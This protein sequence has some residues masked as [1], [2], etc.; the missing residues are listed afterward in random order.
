MTVRISEPEI[1]SDAELRLTRR[2]RI[3]TPTDVVGS[4]N[5]WLPLNR[6]ETPNYWDSIG[7]DLHVDHILEYATD[8]G[9]TVDGVHF[10]DT[11]IGVGTEIPN[12]DIDVYK[13][14]GEI[15][16]TDIGNDEYTRITKADTNNVA[17]RY[18]RVEGTLG[19]LFD[20]TGVNKVE[21]PLTPNDVKTANAFSFGGWFLRNNDEAAGYTLCQGGVAPNY[22]TLELLRTGG[23]LRVYRVAVVIGGITRMNF[24]TA[25]TY[26]IDTFYCAYVVVTATTLVLYVNGVVIGNDGYAG[27]GGDFSGAI[28]LGASAAGNDLKGTMDEWRFYS[29]ALVPATILDIFNSRANDDNPADMVAGYH[30]D[31][32]LTDYIAAYDGT[33]TT[34]VY[35][36]GAVPGLV[37]VTVWDSRDGSALGEQGIITFGHSEGRT[38]LQGQSIRMLDNVWM[39][40]G[41]EMRY[42]D[43]GDS[44]YVGFEAPALAADQIW[45]LPNADGNANELLTT[46]GGGV[47]GW[48]S[49]LGLNDLADP[50]DDRIVFWDDSENA[51]K[52][53]DMGNSV[54]IT[55][56]TLD[57]I[58]DIRTSATPDFVGLTIGGVATIAYSAP[59]L[60]IG[61]TTMVMDVVSDFSIGTGFAGADYGLILAGDT[62]IGVLRWYEATGTLGIWCS[63]G[64]NDND[65]LFDLETTAN[66]VAVGTGTGVTTWDWSGLDF[67]GLDDVTLAGAL[68]AGSWVTPYTKTITVAI[69]GGDYTTIQAAL[70]ANSAGGELFIIYPGTYAN[71]TINFSAN[72]QCVVGA[73]LTPQA[74]ITHTAQICNFGAFTGCRMNNI[75]LVGTYTSAIDMI[76]GTGSLFA[77]DC[78]L[79]VSAS[80]AIAGSPSVL[81]TTGIFTQVRGTLKCDN[82]A[83]SGGQTKRAVTAGAGCTLEFRSV[84]V[85]IDG[86]TASTATSFIYG[87]GTGTTALTR[88]TLDVDDTDAT[89]VVGV[90]LAGSGTNEHQSNNIHVTAGAAGKSGYGYYLSSGTALTLR[91]MYNHIHVVDGG[92]TSIS[93]QVGANCIAISQMDDIVAADGDAGGGTFRSVH[94]PSDENLLATGTITGTNVVTGT[95]SINNNAIVTVDGIPV[96]GQFAHWTAN[97]LAGFTDAQA[98]AALSGGAT[99]AFDFNSQNLTSVGTLS[100]ESYFDMPEIAA[101]ANPAANE[102]RFYVADN[103]GTTTP[104]FLDSAGVATSMIG[105]GGGVAAHAILDGVVHTDSVADGVTRGSLIIGNATPKWD[106]LVIGTGFLGGDGADCTWRSYANTLADLSGHA[107]AAFDWNGA[108]LTTVGSVSCGAIGCGTITSSGVGT[109]QAGALS[110]GVD[111]TTAGYL[112]LYGEDAVADNPQGGAIYF[113]SSDFFEASVD[114]WTIQTYAGDLQFK[115]DGGLIMTMVDATSSINFHT[116]NLHGI[117]TIDC[118]AITSTGAVIGLA[119]TLDTHL[120]TNSCVSTPISWN[121]LTAAPDVVGQGTWIR[122]ILN[123]QLYNGRFTNSS[124]TNG[125]NFTLNFRCPAGTYTLRFNAYKCVLGGIVDVDIDA[126]EEGSFDLY[127]AGAVSLNIE[128]ISGLALSAGAHTLKFR[129]DGTSVNTY[130]FR[131]EGIILQRTA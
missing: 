125:D 102:G 78:H 13:A 74:L 60:T 21:L 14:D 34:E 109:F 2:D 55:V 6:D 29:G 126:S 63:G 38:Q 106:E 27:A 64:A 122:T 70:T 7:W 67:T 58:Q 40:G 104:Y 42:Y 121:M 9:V 76:T 72:D 75:K 23:G 35:G 48:S 51:L 39:V 44:N 41:V 15:R 30:F 33:A 117:G 124:S 65:I 54:A 107:G 108:N 97:G 113:Y 62:T 26:E 89:L 83:N 61:A 25:V 123:S 129:I 69:A 10:L 49:V 12:A 84:M 81:S 90:Y 86:S 45:V 57:T 128:E 50:N 82:S 68:S 52:W 71:D 3:I 80:G 53:L 17:A 1:P 85:D 95:Q 16:I 92:G 105:A 36:P 127:D 101:P 87:A 79:E 120:A 119:P 96:N 73:G 118:G 99:A 130:Q 66:Q 94:S 28:I 8:H 114:H 37:E 4:S 100:L 43:V 103:A 77:R 5:H 59:T 112:H 88:C 24:D 19:L 93:F 20:G 22:V 18:N 31:D 91:S 111:K 32:D 98:M 131:A 56:T 11:Q 110:V 116:R 46:D 47:L 115:T